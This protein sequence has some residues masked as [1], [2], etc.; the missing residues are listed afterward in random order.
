MA[1]SEAL[2]RARK[3][4]TQVQGLSRPEQLAWFKREL[5]IP[6]EPLLRLIGYG[7]ETAKRH[8]GSNQMTLE[9]LAERKPAGTLRVTELLHDLV[10]L[11]GHDLPSVKAVLGKPARPLSARVLNGKRKPLTSQVEQTRLY[12]HVRNGGAGAFGDFVRYL[13]LSNPPKPTG[14]RG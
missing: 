11:Y 4:A 7:P 13:Q 5:D 1:V 9:Q 6:P 8:A 2:T 12:R 14:G 10:S 3:F